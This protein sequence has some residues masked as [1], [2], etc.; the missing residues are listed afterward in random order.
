MLINKISLIDEIL[1]HRVGALSESELKQ[2]SKLIQKWF[3]K[4]GLKLVRE[5]ILLKNGK[6]IHVSTVTQDIVNSNIKCF[7][8]FDGIAIFESDKDCRVEKVENVAVTHN[9]TLIPVIFIGGAEPIIIYTVDSDLQDVID[10]K[11]VIDSLNRM[12]NLD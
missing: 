5:D 11:S 4:D 1:D 12:S 3:T 2:S 6:T 10:S 9:G 7:S 8:A